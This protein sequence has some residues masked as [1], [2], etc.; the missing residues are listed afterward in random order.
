MAR[1]SASVR[2]RALVRRVGRYVISPPLTYGCLL[3][4]AITTILQNVLAGHQLHSIPPHRYTSIRA[5]ATDP[6]G[7]L[8]SS[9][10]WIDGKSLAPYLLAGDIKAVAWNPA[11]RFGAVF[12]RRR[13]QEAAG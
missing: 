1:V 7:V 9:V 12:G 2:A 5:L 3:V 6:L 8:L 4:L 11:E 13:S 10:S